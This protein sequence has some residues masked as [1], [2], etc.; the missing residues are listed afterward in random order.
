MP[1]V[2]IPLSL[3]NFLNSMIV[4]LFFYFFSFIL[5]V[6]ALMTILSQNSIYSVLFLVLSFVSSS[7]ILFLLE[8]EYISLI[9]IIIYVGA[10]AVL[11]LFVVMM[12][13][14]KT[15][16]LAKDSLKYFPFGSFIGIVFLIEI[17][18][19][20]PSTFES[21]NP[22]DASF[23]WNCYFDWFNKLDY[24][25]EVMS[26]GHLLYTDYIIQFLLSGNILLLATIGP[27][28]LVLIR[29]TKITKK[30]VTFKQLS[31]TYSSVL[32]I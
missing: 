22:Y 17:L 12:L 25:N 2:Q 16:Y 5:I 18:L 10:I 11:F 8:C 30:Q 20:V 21:T 24:F 23:L 26:I 15:V 27:V 1:G 7:S 4:N 31:R 29:S 28:T 19:I 13:D 14:V 32:H 3:L 9:F 6:S